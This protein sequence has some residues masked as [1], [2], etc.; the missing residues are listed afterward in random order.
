MACYNKRR[1]KKVGVEKLPKEGKNLAKNVNMPPGS[2]IHVGEQ[3]IKDIQMI[4]TK[5][6]E[7]ELSQS[8]LIQVDSFSEGE[9]K[10][11]TK[12][13]NVIGL[14]EVDLVESLC[15][16]YGVHPLV[17]E[18]ILNTGQAAKVEDYG[19]YLFVNAKSIF[20][21]DSGDLDTEQLSFLLFDD[22]TLISFQ[23]RETDVSSKVNK[24]LVKGTYIRKNKAADLLYGFLDT[25]VDDYFLVMEQIGKQIDEVE[26]EL[27]DQ[28]TEEVLHKIYQL[29]RDLVFMQNTLWPMRN[30]LSTLA[31]GN[32]DEI[33]E[34]SVR[35]Y[36]DVYDHIIQM[37]DIAETYRDISSG[38]LDTY[39]SSISN[40]TNDIM[41]IL[42]IYS[43]IFIPLSFLAGVYG[44]NFKI[45][46][47]LNW[48]YSYPV[49]WLISIGLTLVMLRF[50]KK[51]D[52]L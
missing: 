15:E 30:V 2:A 31:R 18:D 8:E 12:W 1:Y 52:W 14:H 49:F 33:N 40:K 19:N 35:Y 48:E 21:D 29:K 5:Y 41:K 25:I 37:I 42:T 20:F 11:W 45:M 7:K 24:R 46:P 36:R 26:D 6:N 22:Y 51:K 47:E 23:E 27:L 4:Y 50:F 28:P 44:M 38:M 17:I 32:Y 34:K 10:G 39:L 9:E 3:K 13:L 43:T 16:K